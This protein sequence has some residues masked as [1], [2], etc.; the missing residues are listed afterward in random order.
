MEYRC[1]VCGQKGKVHLRKKKYIHIFL[2]ITFLFLQLGFDYAQH[3]IPINEI[4]SGGPDKDGIPA[5][6][7]PEF[8]SGDEVKYLKTSDRILGL[9][10]NGE[11]KAYPIRILNWH[12]LVN[13][14]VGEKEVLVSY[15]PLCGTGMAFDARIDGKRFLFGVSGKLYNSDV[16]M[17]DKQTESRKLKWKR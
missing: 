9:S 13:D 11:A 4:H 2:F 10:I 12:E 1:S 17:Y 16:L 15:C 7:D 3:S 5:L 6:V 14:R 8:I